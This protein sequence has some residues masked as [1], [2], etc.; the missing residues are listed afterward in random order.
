VKRYLSNVLTVG[1]ENDAAP[2]GQIYSIYFL[3]KD[4]G[5]AG[6]IA[7]YL[8]NGFKNLMDRNPTGST[9]T[10]I[11]GIFN[12]SVLRERVIA[13]ITKV[14][15]LK[16]ESP[17]TPTDAD[18]K[19]AQ[20]FAL[21]LNGLADLFMGYVASNATIQA[22]GGSATDSDLEYVIQTEAWDLIAAA[23]SV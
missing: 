15:R 8:G 9:L 21:N 19:V 16:T 3:V 6:E 2:I 14:I 20:A 17:A 22:N 23:L 10:A 1:A 7:Y 12:N 18:N 5:E 13:G 4:E 11:Y